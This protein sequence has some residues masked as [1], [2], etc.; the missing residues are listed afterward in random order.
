MSDLW[1]DMRPGWQRCGAWTQNWGNDSNGKYTQRQCLNAAQAVYPDLGPRCGIHRP[2]KRCATCHRSNCRTEGSQKCL[3]EACN[4]IA[5]EADWCCVTHKLAGVVHRFELPH[6]R[7]PFYF[8]SPVKLRTSIWVPQEL[9]HDLSRG[10]YRSMM[11][12]R[13]RVVPFPDAALDAL[14]QRLERLSAARI[15]AGE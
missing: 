9:Y 13:E 3:L 15:L 8:E 4:A 6:R 12:W 7:V 5:M 2:K 14:V 1:T 10:Y 11:L